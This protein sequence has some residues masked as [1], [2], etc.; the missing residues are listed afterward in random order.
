MAD[1]KDGER[2]ETNQAGKLKILKE[3]VK[4]RLEQDVEEYEKRI[5]GGDEK[6]ILRCN[7]TKNS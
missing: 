2:K 7:K 6:K 4:K 1:D 5:E 3:T